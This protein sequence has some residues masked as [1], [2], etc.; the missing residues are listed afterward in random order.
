[1]L[2]RLIATAAVLAIAA[3]SLGRYRALNNSYNKQRPTVQSDT[4][5]AAVYRALIILL[6]L[7]A[8]ASYW[9][10]DR[11]LLKLY[12]SD[13]LR[14]IGSF[15]SILGIFGFEASVRALG[16]H[17]SPCFDLRVPARRVIEGPYRWVAHPI[18]MSNIV[19]LLGVFASSGSIWALV[20]TGIVGVY[21]LRSARSEGRVVAALQRQS[22]DAN[23]TLPPA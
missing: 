17:Y 16:A 13:A 1:M 8:I 5:F 10:D 3:F 12:D 15:L 22:P 11:V 21:Y 4:S 18:Y 23:S 6:L 7:I 14:M 2:A 19:I 20:I 9:R